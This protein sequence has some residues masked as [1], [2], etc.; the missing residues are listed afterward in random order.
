[1]IDR[2]VGCSVGGAPVARAPVA[3][4]ATPGTE[5]PVAEALPG[6]R[7]VQGVVPAAVRL[8][9]VIGSLDNV[10]G[11][12]S[13]ARRLDDTAGTRAGRP[14]AT[15]GERAGRGSG[16]SSEASPSVFS[17][18]PAPARRSGSPSGSMFPASIPNPNR[19][20]LPSRLIPVL[21]RFEPVY[22]DPGAL[23]LRLVP[24]FKARSCSRERPPDRGDPARAH[25]LLT[26]PRAG[27]PG[28]WQPSCARHRLRRGDRDHPRS[29]MSEP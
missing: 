16:M 15:P 21:C 27:R 18:R 5:H 23:S 24:A 22:G 19:L 6:P 4:L 12:A 2:Q 28:S 9:G 1:M 11:P 26:P 3:V 20:R 17:T 10:A 25:D 14:S 29:A 8:A 13:S 7:A